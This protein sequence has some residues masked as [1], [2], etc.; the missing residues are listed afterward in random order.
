MI[1]AIGGGE[2]CVVYAGKSQLEL[3]NKIKQTRMM[4]HGMYMNLVKTDVSFG[5]SSAERPESFWRPIRQALS[6]MR[7]TPPQSTPFCRR[8]RD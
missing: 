4:L 7:R 6:R 5:Y 8:T 3:V 1:A 2:F